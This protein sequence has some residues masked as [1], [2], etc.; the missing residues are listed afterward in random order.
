MFLV[1]NLFQEEETMDN[2]GLILG[3]SNNAWLSVSRQNT[4]SQ[5]IL[6]KRISEEKALELS[7]ARIA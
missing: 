5:R 1:H 3:G 2:N 4:E 7:C 6:E